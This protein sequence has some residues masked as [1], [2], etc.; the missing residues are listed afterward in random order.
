MTSK[1]EATGTILTTP[2]SVAPSSCATP[3]SDDA[4]SLGYLVARALSRSVDQIARHDSGVR[5]GLDPEDVHQFRV[6]IRRLRSDLRTFESLLKPRLR[7]HLGGELRW[8][9]EAVGPVRDSDVLAERLDHDT[10]RLR[11]VDPEEEA[12]VLS[13]LFGQ[14]QVGRT[15]MLEALASDR[16]ETLRQTLRRVA[17]RPPVRSKAAALFA[18]PGS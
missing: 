2:Q 4:G 9:G 12:L 16:Y 11:H 10:R 5:A 17:D 13:R 18:Q 6:G 1:T 7:R 3:W 8:L 15:A 14:H